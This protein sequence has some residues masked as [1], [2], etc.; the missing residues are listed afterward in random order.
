MK[1]RHSNKEDLEFKQREIYFESVMKV[2]VSYS[3]PPWRA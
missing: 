3:K 1:S 2:L